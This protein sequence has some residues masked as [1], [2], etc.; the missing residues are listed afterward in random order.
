MAKHVY[1]N[2][3]YSQNVDSKLGL[4]PWCLKVEKYVLTL[5]IFFIL[6]FYNNSMGTGQAVLTSTRKVRNIMVLWNDPC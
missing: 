6:L 2:E 3:K 5:L 4:T 1:T